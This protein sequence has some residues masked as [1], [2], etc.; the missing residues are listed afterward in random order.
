ML[1]LCPVSCDSIL[2]CG[3]ST[4]VTETTNHSPAA[5]LPSFLRSRVPSQPNT[6]QI[7]IMK[8]PSLP[9][10][11]TWPVTATFSPV[12]CESLMCNFWELSSDLGRLLFSFLPAGCNAE[13]MDRQKSCRALWYKLCVECSRTRWKDPGSLMIWEPPYQ[14]WPA[15]IYLKEINFFLL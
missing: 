5:I 14:L 11:W 10:S 12:V 8:F 3:Q 6:W 1:L 15:C 4:N 2:D 9:H 7:S 13:G